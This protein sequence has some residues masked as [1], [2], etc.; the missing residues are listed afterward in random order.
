MDAPE[1]L[2][3]A[4][5]SLVEDWPLFDNAIVA[6]GFAP[7]MRDY[8]VVVV[9]S[10]AVP[11]GSRSYRDGQYRFR[12]THCVVAHVET[13]VRDDVW[14]GSWDDV[15]TDY[16]A[17]ERA[18][19]PGGYVWGVNDM[20]AYPGATYRPDSPRAAEWARRLGRSMHEVRIETSAH[21][22]ELVFHGLRVQKV[23]AGDPATGALA[24]IDPVDLVAPAP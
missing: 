1:R 11:D 16:T 12:F 18:G 9:A 7:Y 23:A 3:P 19:C 4:V 24:P 13:A 17:W 20:A 10:A 22:L 21:T 5:V 14:P 8:E 2:H 15:F 6:H